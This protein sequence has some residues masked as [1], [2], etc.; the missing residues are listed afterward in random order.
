MD[1]NLYE[2]MQK[3]MEEKS[4]KNTTDVKYL[5]VISFIEKTS[6]TEVTI[7]KDIIALIDVTPDG[8]VITKYYDENQNFI[9]GRGVDGELFPSESY[10]NDDLSFL[11]E[12]DN[13]DNSN[14]I[15][16]S[17]LDKNL[18]DIARKLGIS[19][20]DIL[21]MSKTELDEVLSIKDDDSVQLYD[22]VLPGLVDDEKDKNNENALKGISSKQEV[23]LNRKIDDKFTLADVLG[24]PASSKLIVV[25]SDMIKDNSNTTRFSCII[26]GPNGELQ[27]ADMLN[28]V[29]GKDSDKNIYETNRNGSNVDKKVV[30]SSYSINSPLIK[31]GILTIRIGAMG[32]IEVG[33]GQMDKNSHNDAFTQRLE[34]KE[35]YPV[36]RTVRDE[37]SRNNGSDNIS[38]KMD[39]IKEH[40]KNGCNS[41]SLAEADGNLNTGHV[42]CEDASNLILS[43][44]NAKD[45]IEEVFTPR[46][47]NERFKAI[48]AKNPNN[49][50]DE[51]V[52][53]TKSELLADA[54]HLRNHKR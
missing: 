48:Q 24:V 37:F 49:T 25:Y 8:N 7:S 47:I 12:I 50:L 2:V 6:Q 54:E 36:T 11:S 33:Y 34:T 19:K 39:E 17:E 18:S 10:K 32:I 16:L 14:S 22:D 40:E 46:E 23:N 1:K 29:G 43:D 15:S 53:I 31:N 41:F 35:M 3:L 45:K 52:E 26:Q 27:N 9:A 42:H 4:S 30:Q 28:Q 38:N 21:S 51:N 20:T 44:E 13:L 5:G